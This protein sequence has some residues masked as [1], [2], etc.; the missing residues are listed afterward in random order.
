MIKEIIFLVK[1][2]KLLEYLVS[3]SFPIGFI[4]DSKNIFT[5]GVYL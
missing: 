5:F 4:T 1:N 3:V 2:L